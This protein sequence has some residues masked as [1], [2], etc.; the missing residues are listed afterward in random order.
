MTDYKKYPIYK[1]SFSYSNPNSK[2]FPVEHPS[3]ERM[4]RVEQT[5]EQLAQHLADFINN[6]KNIIHNVYI[7]QPDGST[8]KYR[9][10]FKRAGYEIIDQK[11]SE[12]RYESWVLGWFGHETID[13]GEDDQYFINSFHDFVARM[14]QYNRDNGEV[15]RWTDDEGIEH[16]MWMEPVCL[17]GAEDYWRWHSLKYAKGFRKDRPKFDLITKDNDQLPCRCRYCRKRGVV[18]IGH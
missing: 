17:M 4:F 1:L 10:S 2:K 3:N 12:V 14:K 9:K 16:S 18:A 5:P 13:D 7:E 15:H 8:K 11:I 6:F